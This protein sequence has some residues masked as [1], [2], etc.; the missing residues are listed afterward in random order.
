M[1]VPVALA[2]EALKNRSKNQESHLPV[3]SGT[4]SRILITTGVA[5][6]LF[7]MVR[8][9]VRKAKRNA[10]ERQALHPGDPANFAMRLIMAF[11]ND[12]AFGWGTDEAAV[13]R[14]LEEI[15]STSILRRV[16][17]VFPSLDKHNRNLA[18]VLKSELTTEEFAI[19]QEIINLK[20]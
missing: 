9:W 1:A 19:A 10:Q 5:I 14:T 20:H 12:N 2:L 3:I 11:E 17:K 7:F 6:G 15:P 18:A 16:I 13:F 4:A 8:R